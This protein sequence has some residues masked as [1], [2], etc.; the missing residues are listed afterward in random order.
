MQLTNARPGASGRAARHCKPCSRVAAMT[1]ERSSRVLNQPTRRFERARSTVSIESSAREHNLA[2]L[3][4]ASAAFQRLRA[5]L[6]R[7]NTTHG[8]NDQCE[9][10]EG[11]KHHIELVEPREDATE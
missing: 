2:R 1:S 9:V 8:L 10:Y 5:E 3:P 7:V 11:D 6:G 4:S